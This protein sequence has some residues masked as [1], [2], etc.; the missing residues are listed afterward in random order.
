MGLEPQATVDEIKKA[1]RSQA[2][3]YHPD[4]IQTQDEALLKGAQQ[5]FLQ[6][7][8]AYETLKKQRGF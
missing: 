7:Q 2:K 3:K 6:I 5:K 4:R 1:Y 8:E